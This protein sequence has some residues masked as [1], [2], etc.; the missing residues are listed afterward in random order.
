M[1]NRIDFF[2]SE[3]TSLALPA[4][5]V[6]IFIDG[7]LC[8]ALEPIEIVRG[9]WPEFSWARLAY[10]QAA[11][12]D[13]VFTA[14][15]EIESLFAIG[16]NISIRALY[17]GTPP[18]VA[19]FSLPIFVGQIEDVQLKLTED[20][21][22]VEITAR[23]FSANLKRTS[24][25]G[26]RLAKANG[27]NMFLAGFDTI[28]NPDC[29]AN[30]NPEPII[31]NGTS[32]TAFY[33]E[34]SEGKLWGYA[35]VI[36]YLLCEYV[37]TGQLQTPTIEQLRTLTENQI[38]RDLDVTGLN[39]AQA[40]H[41]CCER[42]GLKFKFVPRLAQSGPDQAIVFYK[43][44]TG[45]TIELNCQQKGQQFSISKTNITA[46]HSERKCW[47]ITHK[48]VGQGD[49]K[50]YEA[51]FELIKAWD[52]S[53]ED[54]D[55][56]KFSPSTNPQFYKVKDVYRK[57]SLNEA[58]QYSGAPYNQGDAFDFTK[59]FHSSNFARRSRRFRP[60]LTTDKQGKSLGY[61]LQV[62]YDAG[63]NWWQYLY[64]FNILLDE[65]GIWLSSDQL[66]IET[67]VAALRG[68]L[69]F[70]IT[71]SV[72]SDERI[73]CVV[74]DGPINSTAPVV[75]HIITLPRQF[76]YRKV[77]EN[78]IFAGAAD[79]AIGES[80]EV[81]DSAAL[82]DFIRHRAAVGMQTIETFDIQ[83]PNLEF[84]YMLGDMVSTSPESKDLLACRGDSHSKS[85]IVRVQMDFKKQ[86]TKLKIVRQRN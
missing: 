38:V 72:I 86:C 62:S 18:G 10:N 47:P 45:R 67:W 43:T 15:E 51:T 25:Y 3:Q 54:T 79:E 52:P 34:P 83:T 28:F 26:Q 13:A 48:Y 75:E 36:D 56:N 7:V 85:R 77:T 20:T 49:F 16:K 71:A 6:S 2:Q 12:P 41:R 31:V 76:K 50:I 11:Y 32:Y 44:G 21:E 35:E 29:K 82:Y 40:L 22:S 74:A 57:W 53:L 37:Q 73:S 81:D 70:R 14:V 42:I 9:S 5:S 58:G 69:K 4:A 64:A 24:V 68:L 84:D 27:A 23:D 61:Y 63:L 39:L 78:S 46:L 65:C 1:S 80:D 59:I 66:D 19:P 30:A 60:S 55:Y 33:P 8:P 17:N